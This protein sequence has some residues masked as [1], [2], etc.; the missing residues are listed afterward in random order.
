M[1]GL[2][3]WLSVGLV[4]YVYAGYPVLVTLLAIARP[5]RPWPAAP[6]PKVSLIVAA[7]NEQAVIRA[8]LTG[9]LALD[10][11]PDL[12]Q[13]I[14]VADGSDDA[15]VE[16]ASEF[17]E[18]G[19]EVMHRPE[20]RGKMAAITRAMAAATGEIVVFSDA[21]NAFSP[22]AI[23]H[24]VA[25]YADARVGVT[26]GYKQVGG[27]SAL[28]FSEGA[29]WRYE[30]HIRRMETRLGC[31]VGVN[32]EI[33]SIRRDLFR[34]APEG[35]INDDQWMAHMVIRSGFDVIFCPDAVSTEEISATPDEETERRSRMVAGQYQVFARAHREIPWRRP[36]VA[37]MLV[38]HKLLRPLVPFGMIGAAIA[39]VW[40]VVDTPT[41]GGVIAL[42]GTWATVAVGLQVAFYAV[43]VAG[44]R[45][46]SRFGRL[47]YV[48][49]FLVDS[50]LAALRGLWRHVTGSQSALWARA[51]RR[52]L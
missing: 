24:L 18:R 37:W 51:E 41:E 8:K 47:A 44:R 46:E 35:T 40:A 45:L 9:V 12:L 43:A 27:A 33:C 11:P 15:T 26:V 13:V 48:P 38:S 49:R 16:I 42:A 39:A 28:G 21:N 10:Y 50:N 34:P 4:A 17:V 19:V 25:P 6:L 7:Y 1:S 23:R 5:V 52:A 22:D 2:T 29:Y 36:L 14:V 20:R 32:G 30:S 31:T 3:F